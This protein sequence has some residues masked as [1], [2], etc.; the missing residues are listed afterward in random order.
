M[1]GTP[2]AVPKPLQAT[3][4]TRLPPAI[5]GVSAEPRVLVAPEMSDHH[6][7]TTVVL[8]NVL[9]ILSMSSARAQSCLMPSSSPLSRCK[10][11]QKYSSADRCLSV[12]PHPPAGQP[13]PGG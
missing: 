7:V 9:W 8:V 11:S 3:E 12:P 6:G 2:A 1:L 5:A 4:R 10:L 13:H